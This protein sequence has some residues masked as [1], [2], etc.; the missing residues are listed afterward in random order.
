MQKGGIR[1]CGHRLVSTGVRWDESTKR[2]KRGQL[3]AAAPK[4]ENRITLMNDNDDKRLVIERCAIRGRVVSNP[5]IDWTHKD[6][7]DYIRSNHMPYNPLYDMGYVMPLSND[8][9]LVC[10]I[11][12]HSL[13]TLQ[14]IVKKSNEMDKRAEVFPVQVSNMVFQF[15]AESLAIQPAAQIEK[16]TR[17]KA[18]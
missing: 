1:S 13:E 18:R 8:K 17:H 6:I 11:S 7:W 5:I 14:E 16:K 2:S 15:D 12:G 3:E 4:V 9:I 10:P